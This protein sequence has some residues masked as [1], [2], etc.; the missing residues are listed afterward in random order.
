MPTHPTPTQTLGL[1]FIRV[2]LGIIF[3]M[4]G[5]GKVSTIGVF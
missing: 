1:F 4:Q 5:Y 3:L 2:L